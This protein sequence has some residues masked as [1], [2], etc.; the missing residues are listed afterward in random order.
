MPEGFRPDALALDLDGTVYLADRPLPGAV[1]LIEELREAGTPFLFATNN[2]SVG[3]THYVQRLAA[4]GID[5]ERANV[6]TSNDVAAAHLVAEGITTAYLVATDEVR[7]EYAAMGIEHTPRGGDAVVLTFDTSLDY[8]KIEAAAKALLAGAPYYAT[9]PDLVCPTPHG[10]VPDCGSFIALFDAATG[11]RPTVLGKPSASM[12]QA[13]RARLASH[14]STRRLSPPERIA[15]V[16]DRLY[17]DVRLANDHGFTAVL[18]L[19]GEATREDAAQSPYRP[20]LIVE[21]LGELH[22]LLREASNRDSAKVGR[23]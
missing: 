17:T 4:M 1:A 16:G 10:P 6:L 19:T 22:Q 9:H 14:A 5:A 15:F 7:A 23:A 20:D 13:V 8:R 3:G 18:T 21:D 11:R 12:A 2:S